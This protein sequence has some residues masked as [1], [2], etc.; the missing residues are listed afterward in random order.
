MIEVASEESK[1]FT[2]VSPEDSPKL[3]AWKKIDVPLTVGVVTYSQ[4]FLLKTLINSF[5]AQRDPSWKMIILHDGPISTPLYESLLNDNYLKNKK[6][7]LLTTDTRHNDYGH[8]LRNL[9]LEKYL[10]T[11]WLL[12]TNGDN[13]YVPTFVENMTEEIEKDPDIFMVAYPA[14][15][16]KTGNA[17]NPDK[18]YNVVKEPHLS[19]GG[20]DMGQFI[21]RKEVASQFRINPTI[22]GDGE[23]CLKCVRYIKSKSKK[24]YRT[25]S[26]D[27]VHNV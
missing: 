13:Y 15:L 8:S 20:I 26:V 3:D 17:L 16:H 11:S 14:I 25:Y 9:I 19:V 2:F 10:T 27:F 1:K 4:N 18:L 5:E 22:I 23:F 24:I 6:I 21:V 12:L 7:I